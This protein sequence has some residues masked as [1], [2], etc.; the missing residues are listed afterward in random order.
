MGVD[1][2]E[3]YD[4]A[5]DRWIRKSRMPRNNW[6]QVAAELDGKIYVIG[7]GFPAGSVLDV[8]YEY[9]PAKDR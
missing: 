2:V 8:L 5:A 3:A 9:D 4:T 6:E 1:I 7:G